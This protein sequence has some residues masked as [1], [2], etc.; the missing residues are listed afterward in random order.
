MQTRTW[1]GGSQTRHPACAASRGRSAG[2]PRPAITIATTHHR[3]DRDED[4]CCDALSCG[5]KIRPPGL[6]SFAEARRTSEANQRGEPAQANQTGAPGQSSISLR[7]RRPTPATCLYQ[8]PPITARK[9]PVPI[10]VPITRHNQPPSQSPAQALR[11]NLRLGQGDRWSA[12]AHLHRASGGQGTCRVDI[13]GVQPGAL[14]PDGR[15]VGPGADL[16]VGA[17]ASG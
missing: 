11:I 3:C 17:F 12:Q 2:R 13:H 6:R 16:R 1:S 10:T 5:S 7:C 15:L 14:G 8:S 9:M 4:G